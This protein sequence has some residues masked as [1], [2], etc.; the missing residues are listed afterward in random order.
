MKEFYE[1]KQAAVVDV[2]EFRYQRGLN[3]RR[4]VN[5]MTLA[6]MSFQPLSGIVISA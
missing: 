2:Q 4:V 6:T 1:G 3:V 5:Q